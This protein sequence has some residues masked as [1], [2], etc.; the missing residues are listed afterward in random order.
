MPNHPIDHWA[1]NLLTDDE[2]IRAK[3]GELVDLG[4]VTLYR[5]EDEKGYHLRWMATNDRGVSCFHTSDPDIAIRDARH[6]AEGTSV[7]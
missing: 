6:W 4:D 5:E 7:D 2:W 1:P 3:R